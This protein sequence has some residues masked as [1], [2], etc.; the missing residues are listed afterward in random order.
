MTMPRVLA[1][2]DCTLSENTFGRYCIPKSSQHRPAPQ[3]VLRGD[4]WELETI[5]F[6]R[7]HV[8]DR[9]IVHAGMFFGDFLP[10]LASAMAPGRTIYAFEPNA[11]NF[12]AAQWTVALNGLS[13]VQL[14]NTGLGAEKKQACM[15]TSIN[16][17]ALGGAS[18]MVDQTG[19]V[20]DGG[21]DSVDLVTIDESLPATADIGILQ[22]DV[23]GYE[24]FAL[25]GGIGTIRR[26]LPI[27]ILET[28]PDA[29]VNRYLV[30]LRYSHA[31]NVCGNTIFAT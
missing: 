31:G 1:N 29:F 18:H 14:F 4:V 11:E 26:C 7:R 8:A 22:L 30:P 16:G 13:N 21:I 25:R 28:V 20:D 6:M 10:G 5:E 12:S 23:E 2:I 19:P 15:R 3:A 24:E 27:I 9:D 17:R